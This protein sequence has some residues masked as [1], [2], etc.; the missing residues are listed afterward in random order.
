[1]RD[2]LLGNDMALYAAASVDAADAPDGLAL[3]RDGVSSF[4]FFS[5]KFLTVSSGVCT[6][7]GG[8]S[9]FSGVREYMAD[10]FFVRSGL[11]GA[12]A[13]KTVAEGM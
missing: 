12:A 9:G 3:L 7:F 2:S 10:F 4:F 11:F 13:V 8:S 1:M 5:F 6:C